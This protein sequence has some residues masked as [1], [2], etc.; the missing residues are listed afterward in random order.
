MPPPYTHVLVRCK[1]YRCQAYLDQDGKWR[2]S[3]SREE[4]PEVLEVFWEPEPRC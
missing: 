1:G 2:D 3:N 4:L